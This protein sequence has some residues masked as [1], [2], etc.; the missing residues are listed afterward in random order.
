[1]CIPFHPISISHHLQ[2]HKSNIAMLHR[3]TQPVVNIVLQ[4]PIAHAKLQII[5]EA[6]II[7]QVQRV[8]Y[9][10]ALILGQYETVSHQLTQVH[11]RGHVVE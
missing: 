9:I 3:G 6:I 10:M 7:H 8:E 1:M 11:G 2:Q 4:V 5:Q